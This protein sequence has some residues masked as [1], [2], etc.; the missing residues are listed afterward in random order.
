MHWFFSHWTLMV[1]KLKGSRR[2]KQATMGHTVEIFRSFYSVHARTLFHWISSRALKARW[3]L[4]Q[5]K[6]FFLSRAYRFGIHPVVS[7]EKQLNPFVAPMSR[8]GQERSIGKMSAHLSGDH[9]DEAPNTWWSTNRFMGM[10]VT[11]VDG[12]WYSECKIRLEGCWGVQRTSYIFV[13]LFQTNNNEF[14]TWNGSDL[15]NNSHC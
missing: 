8:A 13:C 14:R 3:Q 11:A 6:G 12:L 5:I 1:T 7:W 15:G 10:I 9:G 2:E 4:Y